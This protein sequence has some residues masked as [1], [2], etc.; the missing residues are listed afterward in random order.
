[1]RI[2]K[3]MQTNCSE[4]FQTLKNFYQSALE[5]DL[6]VISTDK[7]CK[8]LA[9][10]YVYGGGCEAVVVDEAFSNA[11]LYAQARANIGGGKR[12]NGEYVKLIQ[13]YVKSIISHDLDKEGY[14]NPPDWVYE[15]EK[16]YGINSKSR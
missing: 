7:C 5:F 4:K 15:L 3:D 9:W 11:I 1:M 8:I 2:A 16:E 12:P 14:R 13:Q 6:P 10:V